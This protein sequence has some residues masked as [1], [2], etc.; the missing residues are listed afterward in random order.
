MDR[1][2]FLTAMF[3]VAGAAALATIIRPSDALSGVAAPENGI[4]DKLD[5]PQGQ[6]TFADEGPAEVEPINHRRWERR[7][8][9]RRAWRRVCRTHWRHG[10]RRVR[11]YRRRVWV[12]LRL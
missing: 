12:T 11:C 1:R 10:R 2:Y 9:R 6:D 5:A 8:H 4:L 3:G 7:H